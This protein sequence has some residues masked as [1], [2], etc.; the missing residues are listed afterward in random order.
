MIKARAVYIDVEVEV[1]VTRADLE[2]LMMG[3]K[4][5]DAQIADGKARVEGNPEVLDELASMFVAFTPDFE[6]L[7]GTAAPDAAS[8]AGGYE[9]GPVSREALGGE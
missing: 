9:V 7:P 5:L 1:P 8:K 2:P 6:M 3:V 4:T